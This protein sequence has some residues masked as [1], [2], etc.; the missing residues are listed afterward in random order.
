MLTIGIYAERKSGGWI[1]AEIAKA[2]DFEDAWFRLR[3]FSLN[4]PTLRAKVGIVYDSKSRR[5]TASK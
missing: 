5:V 2:A 4:N 1:L 3:D